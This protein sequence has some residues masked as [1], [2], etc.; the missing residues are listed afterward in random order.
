[1]NDIG[2]CN[3]KNTDLL[4][5]NEIVSL[6]FHCNKCGKFRTKYSKSTLCTACL[7]GMSTKEARKK[8]LILK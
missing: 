2:F 1:M 6:R 4:I 8:G 5:Q 7:F 3:I